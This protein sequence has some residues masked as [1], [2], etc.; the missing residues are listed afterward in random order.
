MMTAEGLTKDGYEIQFGTNVVGPAL[1][2]QLLLPTM[3]ETSKLNRETRVVMLGSASHSMAPSDVY[4]FA[5]FRTTM[6]DRATTQRYTISKL[7]DLHYAKALAEREQS[8]KIIPVHP[9]MV[10]TNLHHAS[11]GFFLRPFLY[12]AIAFATPV[13]KGALSQIW[14]A[15]SPEAKSGQY[16]G[17]VGKAE[18]GS[19]ASQNRELQEALFGYIQTELEGHVEKMA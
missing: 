16:Y 9:G 18:S 15:V 3:R 2:T 1:F 11:A 7:A 8:V 14:A 19:K 13:E 12:A 6:P 4:N 17:P 10:A 5:E